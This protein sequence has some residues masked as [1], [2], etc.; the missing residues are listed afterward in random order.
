MP[1]RS[2]TSGLEPSESRFRSLL[3]QTT[4]LTVCS[5]GLE[6]SIRQDVGAIKAWPFLP[7]YTKVVGYAYEVE[8]GRVRE[9]V[10]AVS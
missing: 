7:E 6:E 10:G 8:S 5:I 1:A 4:V 9:V 3:K 2:R